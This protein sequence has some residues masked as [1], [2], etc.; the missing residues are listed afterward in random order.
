MTPLP[1][2]LGGER[3][4]FRWRGWNV[5]YVIRGTGSPVVFVHSI[6][7]AA[8]N[9]EWRHNVPALAQ[10]DGA[11]AD[12]FPHA[13]VSESHSCY[14]IDLL[15]FGASDRP[16]I[17]YTA[18]LYVD[19]LRDFL[20]EV[21]GEPAVVVGSSLGGTYAVAVAAAYPDLVRAVVAIG[22]AGVTRLAESGSVLN[23]GIQ[24]LLRSTVPGTAMFRA[25]T[26]RGSIRFFLK[27]I[28]AD[29][30]KLTPENVELFHLTA[31]Q[32]NARFAPAA[33]VGMSLNRD[34]RTALP[35]LRCPVMIIWGTDASQTPFRESAG[36]RALVPDAPFVALPGGDLPHD[37]HPEQ[38]NAVLE[39]FL[40]LQ[41]AEA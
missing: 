23:D 30:R 8:W 1:N 41:T 20:K 12:T 3:H 28:Y 32:P 5:A 2:T 22:P 14:A 11:D 25:L 33:F 15:G 10:D 29:P 16:P 39:E 7:A 34:I 21:V 27:D 36:V 40:R 17:R 18:Q 31:S 37:E 26:S 4:V 19:L 24:A 38:F 9:A 6:H 35:S 13:H